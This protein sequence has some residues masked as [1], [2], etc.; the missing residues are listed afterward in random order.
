MVALPDY[1][2]RTRAKGKDYFY[3]QPGRCTKDAGPRV[4]LPDDPSSPA[5]WQAYQELSGQS[6]QVEPKPDAGTVD[7]LIEAY[8]AS[9]EFA[10]KSAK[11]RKDY[12][13]YL[14]TLAS[15]LG[16]L[17]VRTIRPKHVLQLRDSFADVPRKADYLISVFSLLVSW[18]IP[19][20]FTDQNPCQHIGH[21]ARTDG[22][23]PW[24]WEDVEYAREHL[25]AHLWY[26]AALALFTG[27]RQSDVL[28]MDWNAI[29]GGEIA[30]RQDKTGKRLWIPLHSEL[31]PVLDAVP[32]VSTRILTNSR[33]L[34]WASGFRA[35]WQGTMNDV[36]FERFRERR[37]VF[38]GLRKSAVCML[39]ESGCT[40]GE[41]AAITGQSRQMVEH[42]SIMVNQRR[43]ARSA[44]LRWEG[45]KK[46]MNCRVRE[47][48]KNANCKTP[49]RRIAKL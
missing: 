49:A 37:L 12:E 47:R 2:F 41:V 16:Q 5:F 13:R 46:G 11:T 24:E 44:I 10:G 36:A 38:H 7:A 4:R 3:Y 15:I 23:P 17:N 40:D 33:G 6:Q 14:A 1:V 34:P 30:V 29:A 20:D 35:A 25:P 22:Y 43:L 45:S 42:Y 18:G 32:R 27:Q 19:R 28:R 48:P 39:L 26:A 8:K 31:R 21:L 9:P